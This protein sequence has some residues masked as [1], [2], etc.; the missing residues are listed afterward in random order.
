MEKTK[1]RKRRERRESEGTPMPLFAVQSSST[2]ATTQPV[3][4]N[5]YQWKKPSLNPVQISVSVPSFMLHALCF[6]SMFIPSLSLSR[7]ISTPPL[8]PQTQL[9][10]DIRIK[11]T[12]PRCLRY[13]PL[14]AQEQ[15]T[16]K[17]PAQRRNHMKEKEGRK[18]SITATRSNPQEKN[19][20]V[21]S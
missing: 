7:I 14:V 5:L 17:T 2:P 15:S 13:K 16:L 9:A 1:N 10:P 18:K 6:I 3:I 11:S 20:K 19:A 12:R 21:N 8:P 4:S